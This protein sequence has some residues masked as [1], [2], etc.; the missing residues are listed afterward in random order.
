[1]WVSC[2][3]CMASCSCIVRGLCAEERHTVLSPALLYWSEKQ[4]G[5]GRD[6]AAYRGGCTS[7]EGF[8][9]PAEV[10]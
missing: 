4:I 6:H 2:A 9:S 8:L 3:W 5:D 1:M 7:C 10:S